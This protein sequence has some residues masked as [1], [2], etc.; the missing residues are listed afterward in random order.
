[1]RYV[2]E[3]YR[4]PVAS[5]SNFIL[6]ILVHVAVFF[7]FYLI[8]RSNSKPLETIIPLDLTVVVEENLDGVDDE[9]PPLT[10]PEPEPPK[11]PE[12][13]PPPPPEPPPEPEPDQVIVESVVS[14]VAEKVEEKKPEP[15]PEPP[16]PKE[17][18]PKPK[19]EPPPKPKE[20]PKTAEQLRQERIAKM[21][22]A[23][24]NIDTPAPRNPPRTNGRTG[25]KT[26][27]AE[28]IQR[29]LMQGYRPGKTEQLAASEEAR[30]FQ[31][32]Q[33]VFYDNWMQPAY[34]PN[35]RPVVLE[36]SFALDGTIRSS[37]I[38]SSSGHP[39]VDA[40][41][42]RAATAVG[43]VRGLSRSFLKKHSV[44]PI[45]FKLEEQ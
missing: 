20:P 39:E 25:P 35:L 6:A 33:Q 38:V 19:D 23:A 34:I 45:D 13:E 9:P 4:P 32:I 10:P 12:V 42:K 40:S 36:V 2:D 22:E 44:V 11:E 37:R 17:E 29:R 27:S 21:R 16:K 14:N 43:V 1:M 26:L 24:K 5:L 30:S 18:P 31:Q 41:V 7:A 3:E 28:E 8:G 15:P